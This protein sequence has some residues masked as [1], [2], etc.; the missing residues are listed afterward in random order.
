MDGLMWEE[1]DNISPWVRVLR[2]ATEVKLRRFRYDSPKSSYDYPI[3]ENTCQGLCQ[4]LCQGRCTLLRATMVPDNPALY[5]AYH[6]IVRQF[7]SCLYLES[8]YLEPSID[9]QGSKVKNIPLRHAY[10]QFSCCNVNLAINW[11]A[12]LFGRA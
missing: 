4:G 7:T 6:V 12:P 2:R 8:N 11:H 3:R 10:R 9:N 1:T 5:I